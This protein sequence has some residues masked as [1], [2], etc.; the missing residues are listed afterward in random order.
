M[1]IDGKLLRAKAARPKSL[2]QTSRASDSPGDRRGP[3]DMGHTIFF[4]NLPNWVTADDIRS[5]LESR[6]LF[7]NAVRVIRD[8]ETQESK[9]YAFVEAP[10]EEEMIAIIRRFNR[11][12]IDGKL[13]RA[14]AAHPKGDRSRQRR[15][16]RRR[17]GGPRPRK[18]SS[19]KKQVGAFGE[20]LQKAL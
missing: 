16:P 4:G 7:F 20:A 5:W 13:L 3:P 17:S 2:R 9:G 14:K 8:F 11:A 15:P 10:N 12:P 1:P 19:G 18:D 6:D